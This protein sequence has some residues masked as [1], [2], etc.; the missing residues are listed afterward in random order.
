M[1]VIQPIGR[2]D[3]RVREVQL[4][5][6]TPEYLQY[7]KECAAEL[8][9]WRQLHIELGLCNSCNEPADLGYKTCRQHRTYYRRAQRK[10][11]Q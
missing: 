10:A 2:I 8:R 11:R 3:T 5:K 7:R 1:P 4:R 9:A 6:G